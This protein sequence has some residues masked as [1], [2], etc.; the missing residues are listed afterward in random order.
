M[1]TTEYLCRH[2]SRMGARLKVQG[3]RARQGEKIEIDVGRDRD[4]EF[5][6][7]RCQDGVVREILDVRPVLRH[8]VLMVRDG[9]DK[10]KFLLGRDERHWF[11]ANSTFRSSKSWQEVIRIRVYWRR[12]HSKNRNLRKPKEQPWECQ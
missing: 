1:T 4:G 5:F 6:D 11:A 3:P 9:D 8:L 7:V 2:F 12:D 10:N